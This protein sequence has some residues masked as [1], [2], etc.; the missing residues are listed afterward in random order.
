[1]RLLLVVIG[2]SN[3]VG[4]GALLSSVPAEHLR[5]AA[6]IRVMDSTD[7]LV[8]PSESLHAGIDPYLAT[9]ATEGL[10]NC[11]VM[12]N[13]IQDA[14]PELD[15]VIVPCALS[16]SALSLE[17]EVAPSLGA[18]VTYT[19]NRLLTIVQ[20]DDVVMVSYGQG[21]SEALNE[22]HA[23]AWGTY[24]SALK[25]HIEA[26]IGRETWWIYSLLHEPGP[27]YDY[28]SNVLAA[29]A[30]WEATDRIPVA[31]PASSALHI[32]AT[33]QIAHGHA[34]GT[35]AVTLLASLIGGLVSKAN[36]FENALLELVFKNTDFE[37]IGDAGGLLGSVTPGSLYVSLHT[38]DPGE[39]GTQETNE[40]AYGDY[41]RV[42]VARSGAGWVVT[43]NSVSPAA[44]VEF[45]EA[46]SGSETATHW[47][48]GSATSGAGI[49]LYKGALSP[50]IEVN[51]GVVPIVVSTSTITED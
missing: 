23:D 7:A 31:R 11:L 36:T 33:N 30:T 29:Q 20:P 3:E 1:M 38:S 13:D 47:A 46:A 41:A 2:Q 9:H 6:T 12:A 27:G 37:N 45:P 39:A 32:G 22:T 18:R 34:K 35:A 48:V 24:S 10:G 44:D 43:G 15:I 50:V 42:A 8:A 14:Y 19:V 51:E 16:G 40:C 25:D 17:W 4:A 26:E 49:L 21:E 5:H 28:W